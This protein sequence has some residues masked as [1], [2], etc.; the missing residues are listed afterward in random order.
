MRAIEVWGGVL[1]LAAAAVVFK[2]VGM[3]G[4]ATAAAVVT[5]VVV[6][7]RYLDT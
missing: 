4:C 2:L 6:G 1:V 3:P 5:I 7:S